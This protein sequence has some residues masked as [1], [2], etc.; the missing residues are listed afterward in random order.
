MNSLMMESNQQKVCQ[1][2]KWSQE[3]YAEYQYHC[4]QVFLNNWLQS[5]HC[6][7]VA[8]KSKVFWNWYKNQWDKI[9]ERYIIRMSKRDVDA[10]E[11]YMLMQ[12][13]LR[14]PYYPNSVLTE[15]IFKDDLKP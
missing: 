11:L 6:V 2:L 9:N 15:A 14:L 7:A 13:P 10:F 4:G 8:E 3:Q 12:E 1:L 5:S